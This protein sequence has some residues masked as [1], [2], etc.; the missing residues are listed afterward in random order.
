V[1]LEALRAG[2]PV[3]A[4]NHAGIPEIIE[5]G[6]TGLIVPERD[7]AALAEAMRQHLDMGDQAMELVT[8]AQ[9]RLREDFDAARQSRRL[10]DILL[11]RV[12]IAG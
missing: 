8:K 3:I 9:Q 11:G 12:A 1:V 2:A 4:S 10:Q 5:H 6:K 7:P